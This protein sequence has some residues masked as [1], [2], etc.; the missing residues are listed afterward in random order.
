[1]ALRWGQQ[2]NTPIKGVLCRC[3]TRTLR[4]VARAWSFEWAFWRAWSGRPGLEPESVLRS[5]TDCSDSTF[6]HV[7]GFPIPP[8]VAP[9]SSP[10]MPLPVLVALEGVEPP[11]SEARAPAARRVL[12]RNEWRTVL[13]CRRCS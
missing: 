4:A 3:P 13:T 6:P 12:E 10:H 5:H 7:G 2:K 1:M 8:V 11:P 9:S